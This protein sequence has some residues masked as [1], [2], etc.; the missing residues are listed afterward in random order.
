MRE[1]EAS[2]LGEKMGLMDRTDVSINSRMGI[3]APAYAMKKRASEQRA[4]L[5]LSLRPRPPP[6][7]L[8]LSYALYTQERH[9]RRCRSP[10]TYF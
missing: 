9:Q 3:A 6:S 5:S 7:P 2:S 1:S 10:K 8:S 4:R